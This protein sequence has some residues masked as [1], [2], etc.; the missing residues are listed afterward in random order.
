[1][2][3][4]VDINNWIACLCVAY[5]FLY[6]V[7]AM[8]SESAGR[9]MSLIMIA[10]LILGMS[11][12]L[13]KKDCIGIIVIL[14]FVLINAIRFGVYYI[15]HQDFYGMIFLLLTFLYYTNKKRMAQLEIIVLNECF[16]KTIIFLFY[17]ALIVSVIFFN[18]LQT[19]A[20][21]GVSIPM[22][23]GPYGLPH[24]LA[25]SLI[26]IYAISSILWHKYKEKIYL[27]LIAIT[28]ICLIWTGVRSAILVLAVML[29]Y[30]Y[31]SIK[32][33][34][35]KVIVVFAGGIVFLYL[36]FF[37]DIIICIIF[38]FVNNFY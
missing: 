11:R 21:W 6:E 34:T 36:L 13:T 17:F 37:T 1:M 22:L 16:S 9:R 31:F 10:L 28:S 33:I 35:K 30:D 4:K 2:K 5:P 19:N 32:R 20:D 23:Y 18:G 12:S 29:I 14:L 38:L 26:A 15:F 8:F 24:T 25:Y 7:A 27:L 3:I